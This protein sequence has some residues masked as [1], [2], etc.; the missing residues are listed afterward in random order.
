MLNSTKRLYNL[1]SR[2]GG[3][4]GPCPTVSSLQSCLRCYELYN[5]SLSALTFAASCTT[6]ACAEAF[7]T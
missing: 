4:G 1:Q 5:A 6:Q 3:G 7:T 2:K